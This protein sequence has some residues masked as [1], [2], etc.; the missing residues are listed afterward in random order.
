MSYRSSSLHFLSFTSIDLF[1]LFTSHYFYLNNHTLFRYLKFTR[2]IFTDVCKVLLLGKRCVLQCLLK[3]R[4]IFEH[5]DSHY[6]LNKLFLGEYY[7][8]CIFVLYLCL[9]CWLSGCMPTCVNL[10]AQREK[11]VFIIECFNV[12]KGFCYS[13]KVLFLSL[14]THFELFLACH[15]II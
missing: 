2:K 1:S 14:L 15:D 10:L 6:L 4:S 5:T 11:S 7:A 13:F 8:D 12:S 9:A 3:I